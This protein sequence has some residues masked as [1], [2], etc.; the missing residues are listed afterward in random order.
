LK[1]ADLVKFAKSKP[2]YQ[3]AKLDKNTIDLEIDHVKEGLPEPTEEELLQDLAY[4]EALARK[5][6]NVKKLNKSLQPF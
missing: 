3:L 2:D 4:R 6:K 1:R 5:K